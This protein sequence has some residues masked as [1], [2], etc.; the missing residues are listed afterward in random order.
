MNNSTDQ[1]TN[2]LLQLET[3]LPS[4]VIR[5]IF[6]LMVV[7]LHSGGL[8]S[9]WKIK[10]IRVDN[11]VTYSNKVLQALLITKVNS[12]LE[13]SQLYATRVFSCEHLL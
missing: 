2:D 11:M 9:L 13:F 7:L 3:D 6:H 8:Y 5:F 12:L 10:R 4:F 1:V